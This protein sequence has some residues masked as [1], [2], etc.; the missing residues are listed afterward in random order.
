ML[1]YR[2]RVGRSQKSG[3]TRLLPIP[4]APSWE[5]SYLP[6]SKEHAQATEHG[7][8]ACG[9]RGEDAYKLGHAAIE[10]RAHIGRRT[11]PLE[12]ICGPLRDVQPSESGVRDTGEGRTCCQGGPHQPQGTRTAR[13]SGVWP[14]WGTVTIRE[15]RA[16]RGG[17]VGRRR[18]VRRS[19]ERAAPTTREAGTP[20]TGGGSMA[21]GEDDI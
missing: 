1:S 17:R 9:R 8:Q 5:I 11:R 3:F 20:A 18:G 12:G 13:E 7:R 14:H 4:W 16:S 19:T 21:T 15:R 2:F 10:E 6:L